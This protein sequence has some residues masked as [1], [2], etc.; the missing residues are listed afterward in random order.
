MIKLLKK[1]GKAL[2]KGKMEKVHKYESMM[3]HLKM[4]HLDSLSIPNKFF[5]TMESAYAS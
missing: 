2:N 5:C 1:R 4:N 3:D